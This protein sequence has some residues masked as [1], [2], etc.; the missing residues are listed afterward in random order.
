[1]SKQE[2]DVLRHESIPDTYKPY[3]MVF[4]ELLQAI[5]EA[6][7]GTPFT[8]GATPL[9]QI[10]SLKDQ[11]EV[12]SELQKLTY[13]VFQTVPMEVAAYVHDTF[14]RRFF[15]R[16]E[17]NNENFVTRLVQDYQHLDEPI[18]A[19][20]ERGRRGEASPAELILI[21]DVL[22]IRSVELACLTHPYGEK[23]ELLDDMRKA[24]KDSIVLYEGE[25]DEE[26]ES[27]YRIKDVVGLEDENLL[28]NDQ[29][30][31]LLMTRKRT[32]GWLPDG[33]EVRERSSFVL[34][35]DEQSHL[36]QLLGPEA[37]VDLRKIYELTGDEQEEALKPYKL[38]LEELLNEQMFE[39]DEAIPISTTI[40]AFNKQTSDQVMA[41]AS[42]RQSEGEGF[43]RENNPDDLSSIDPQWVQEW[44]EQQAIEEERRRAAQDQAERQRIL[45]EQLRVLRDAPLEIYPP[46]KSDD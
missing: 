17:A 44:D 15:G 34:R 29:A 35:I 8:Y 30:P 12:H 6:P 46:T 19:M 23:I 38:I 11:Q 14:S 3:L 37:I 10:V 2:K 1:M 27:R 41:E 40:Y 43:L 42:R 32:L 4:G 24:V 22:G 39:F 13:S 45:M 9:D 20:I 7:K 16:G 36:F 25:W 31:G 28:I 33:T 21:R 26:T 18:V 5:L